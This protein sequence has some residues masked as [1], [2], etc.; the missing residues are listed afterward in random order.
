MSLA[1]AQ[2]IK[3]SGERQLSSLKK[4]W[5][6]E[7]EAFFASEE[8]ALIELRRAYWNY[9]FRAGEEKANEAVTYLSSLPF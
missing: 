5:E 9:R 4:S 3:E 7:A 8:Y 6:E 2:A 1:N